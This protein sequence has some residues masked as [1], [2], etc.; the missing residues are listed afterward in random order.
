MNKILR[1]TLGAA[2]LAIFA[3]CTCI[4]CSDTWDEHYDSMGGLTFDGTTMGYLQSQS[5][6][7]DFVE[8]LK[9]S[10]YDKELEASQVLT[11]MAPKN[12]TFNKAELLAK[13]A[14]GNKK[15]VVEEFVENHICRYNISISAKPQTITMLN[16]KNVEVGTLADATVGDANAVSANVSCDNGVVH[17]LDN[18]LPYQF[19]IYEYIGKN[20]NAHKNELNADDENFETWYG[21][22]NELYVDSLDERRSVSRGVDENGDNIWVD[23]VVISN[24]K[25]LRR[26]DAYLYRED[27]T[28]LTLL[29]SFE[30][31]NKRYQGIRELFNWNISYNSDPAVRDSMSR[32]FAHYYT[33]CDL[34]YNMSPSQNGPTQNDSLFSTVFHRWEWPYHVYYNP[35]EGILANVKEK[36]S[37][38]NGYV[39]TIDEFP[40]SV[41]SNIFRELTVEGEYRN[42]IYEDGEKAF[43]N[44]VTTEYIAVSNSADSISGSG[45]LHISP[46]TSNRN[47]EITFQIPNTLSGQYDIYIKFLPIQ[48]Y[49]STKTKLPVQFR[50]SIY[51]R[52]A[53]NG[54]YPAETKPTFE[55]Q[56]K[57][58][59]NFQTKPDSI[60]SLY[61]GTYKFNYCY[62]STSAGVLMK[63]ES[64]VLGSQSSKFTKEMLIDKICLVPNRQVHDENGAYIKQEQAEEQNSETRR[65]K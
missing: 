38:S 1:N 52:N 27:S 25:I 43:T 65:R 2:A 30:A 42:Y 46:K 20:Y 47:T 22:L 34:S 41:Y 24:N 13:I 18:Y 16:D 63:I 36:I 64:Y 60:D 11:V 45:Y 48:V 54:A 28:Y 50:A 40:F 23:S 14:D 58:S 21:Y 4:S 49:D 31:Y 62:H 12:G 39:W 33:M 26:M 7:S 53:D 15:E 17:V 29:P 57:G 5:D 10:G 51:E 37:C 3:I 32:Y 19:N 6:L 56:N 8:I 9:A 59:K 35:N 44:D 55:F 61:V